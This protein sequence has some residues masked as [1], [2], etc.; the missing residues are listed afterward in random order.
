MNGRSSQEMTNDVSKRE[1]LGEFEHINLTAAIRRNFDFGR[2]V[3]ARYLLSGVREYNAGSVYS[4]GE[5]LKALNGFN[6]TI[7]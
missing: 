1:D 5:M 2:T 3:L 4:N 7:L 6:V